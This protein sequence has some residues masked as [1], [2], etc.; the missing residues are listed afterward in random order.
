[1][2][3]TSQ[4]LLPLFPIADHT[5]T[6]SLTEELIKASNNVIVLIKAPELINNLRIISEDEVINL[7]LNL[8]LCISNNRLFYYVGIRRCMTHVNKQFKHVLAWTKTWY[9]STWASDA[10]GCSSE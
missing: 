6:P 1:M 5:V 7:K 4:W 3:A 9:I 2:A 8:Y 10:S